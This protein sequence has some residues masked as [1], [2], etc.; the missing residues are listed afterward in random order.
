MTGPI[1]YMPTLGIHGKQRYRFP[2]NLT[3]PR[4]I[5]GKA[6]SRS[7]SA[8]PRGGL[9]SETRNN[10][11][12]HVMISWRKVLHVFRPDKLT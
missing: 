7:A 1:G 8:L 10:A 6:L 9:A 2:E 4:R 3:G 11:D 5:E 12:L